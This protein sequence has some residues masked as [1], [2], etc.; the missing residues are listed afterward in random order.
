M[1]VYIKD[2][3]APNSCAEC[4]LLEKCKVIG[5]WITPS[6]AH[7]LKERRH[8]NCPIVEETQMS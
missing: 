8:K 4:P 1:G 5:R 7:E 6:K 2:M 3:K